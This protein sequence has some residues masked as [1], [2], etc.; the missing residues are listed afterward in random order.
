MY[1]L[2]TLLSTYVTVPV[3]PGQRVPGRDGRPDTNPVPSRPGCLDRVKTLGRTD[4]EYRA[5]IIHQHTPIKSRQFF[6]FIFL[7]WQVSGAARSIIVQLW[8]K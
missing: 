7:L 2:L 3:V 1:H 6:A 4:I 8:C 5:I